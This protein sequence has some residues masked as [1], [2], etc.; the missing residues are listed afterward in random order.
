ML[1][2]CARPL[3]AADAPSFEAMGRAPISGGDRVRAR[4]RAL[5]EAFQRVVEAAVAALLGPE[6][7]TKRASD[8][9][10]KIMPKAKS[11]ITTYRVI[12]EGETEAGIFDVH[13]SAEIS[14]DRLVRDLAS[15]GRDPKQ[16]TRP[17]PALRLVLCVTSDAGAALPRLDAALRAMLTARSLEAIATERCADD[18]ITRAVQA[19]AARGA[20]VAEVTGGSTSPIRGTA[21]VGRE[22]KLVL[23]MH[24]PDGRRSAAGQAESA[25]YGVTPLG[26]ADELAM[27]ALAQAGPSIE[28]ALA[29]LGGATAKGIVTVRLVGVVRLGH[30]ASIRSAIERLSGIESVEPRRFLPG[31][32]GTIELGVRTALAPRGVADAIS[33]IGATYGLRARELDGTVV[34]DVMDKLDAPAPDEGAPR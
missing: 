3:S 34:V 8:L 19:T 24:D 30:L 15:P 16:P 12:E 21:L 6:T 17:Q 1:V 28:A 29:G 20:L 33:R 22:G 2:V 18:E 23:Q 14:A 25:G 13:V 7:L 5:D 26:A 31:V 11:Y 32:P 4:Q 9:R 10:L 27:H